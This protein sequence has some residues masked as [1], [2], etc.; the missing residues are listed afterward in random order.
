MII[1]HIVKVIRGADFGSGF[2]FSSLGEGGSV[3]RAKAAKVSMI[4]FT[5]RS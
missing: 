2:R 4:R 1:F 3:A 5:Q